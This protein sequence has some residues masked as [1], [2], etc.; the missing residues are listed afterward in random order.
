LETA[1]HRIVIEAGRSESQYWR[2]LWRYREL[3]YFL[4]W[5]DILVRYKQTVVGVA[6]SLIRPLLTMI[7]F[8]LV[9]GKLAKLSSAGVP[10]P[11]LVMTGMLPWQ[12]FATALSESGNSL[13]NNTGMITKV[14]FPRMVIPAS[15]VVTSL[16]DF[17]ISCVL[18]AV[19]FVWYR[20][21]P[22]LQ[23]LALPMFILLSFAAACG[24]GLWIAAL[25]AQYRDFR[26]IVPFVVQFGL[27]VSPVGFSSAIVPERWRLFYS[28]N[29]MVGIIDGFRWALLG[30]HQ[31]LDISE[32]A[33]CLVSTLILAVGGV[34]YFRKTERVLA[35]VI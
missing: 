20:F 30:G 32:L 3:L 35:D 21:V 27:Y 5:R 22:G 24:V 33:V 17:L 34:W 23:V 1:Q 29:P 16:V 2:D 4:A 15:S 13:V 12:F 19:L 26:F 18:L 25:I 14:Y 8:A 6:W 7:V 11:L 9:F 31:S 10:Y 28:L